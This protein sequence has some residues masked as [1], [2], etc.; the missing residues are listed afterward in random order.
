ML[1]NYGQ[2][3]SNF[4]TP[5]GR[6]HKETQDFYWK[7]VKPW[8]DPDTY[9]LIIDTEMGNYKEDLSYYDRLVV[10][11][12][13]PSRRQYKP[14][15]FKNPPDDVVQVWYGLDAPP[16]GWCEGQT[17]VSGAHLWNAEPYTIPERGCG[18]EFDVLLLGA[19]KPSRR[20][21]LRHLLTG[22]SAYCVGGDWRDILPGKEYRHVVFG[23]LGAK[24]VSPENR[25]R[26]VKA[27]GIRASARCKTELITHDPHIKS[28]MSIRLPDILRRGACPIVDLDHDPNRLL[29]LTDKLRNNLYVNSED[30]VHTA[31]RF[32][33][34][35]T[36]DD[37]Q[38]EYDAQVGRAVKDMVAF[39][40]KIK[41]RSY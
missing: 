2:T 34:E 11:M 14:S 22:V 18:D 39:S 28:F 21:R 6:V 1:I 36:L 12:D 7:H 10:L 13:D 15:L 20:K 31:V 25:V 26:D 27:V 9:Y 4:N 30:D 23:S 32:S 16:E 3:R 17:I 33:S 29:L 41:E 35:V 19:R 24:K 38:L 40:K 8:E 37:L 5:W